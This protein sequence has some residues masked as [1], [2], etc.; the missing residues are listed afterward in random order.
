MLR[1][2]LITAVVAVVSDGVDELIAALEHVHMMVSSRI[3]GR[4]IDFHSRGHHGPSMQQG[5]MF[6]AARRT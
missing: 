3:E 6:S 2:L 5:I 4:G 1:M